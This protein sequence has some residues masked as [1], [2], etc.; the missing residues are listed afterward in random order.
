LISLRNEAGQTVQ[1]WI[2]HR[3]VP[4]KYTGPSLNIK[5]DDVAMEELV[6]RAESVEL[7]VA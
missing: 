5:G 1:T 2:L 7:E 4:S 6:L 3:A